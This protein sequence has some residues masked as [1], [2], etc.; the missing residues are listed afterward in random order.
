[1]TKREPVR[2]PDVGVN[3]PELW[4]D[5]PDDDDDFTVFG[6][7]KDPWWEAIDRWFESHPGRAGEARIEWQPRL[8]YGTDG[9][10]SG[11]R[12]ELQEVLHD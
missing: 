10:S 3:A 12:I 8:A 2:F 6:G 1:M 11:F 7:E 4:D 9:G 5:D